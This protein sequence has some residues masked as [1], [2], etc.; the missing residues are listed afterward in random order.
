VLRGLSVVLSFWL[1]SR[2]G[3]MWL[4]GI[5]CL[6]WVV[7]W[8]VGYVCIVS[9][10]GSCEVMDSAWELSSYVRSE[11]FGFCYLSGWICGFIT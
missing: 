1:G 6:C 4:Y 5:V 10:I 2:S 3:G 9:G 11:D 8:V 7:G